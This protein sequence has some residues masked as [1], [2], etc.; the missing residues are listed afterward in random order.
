MEII[1][2]IFNSYT[3]QFG[4]AG[5]CCQVRTVALICE[6]RNRLIPSELQCLKTIIKQTAPSLRCL[7][8]ILI[9]L[10]NTRTDDQASIDSGTLIVTHQETWHN[11]IT[12]IKV[13]IRSWHSQAL[14][15]PTYAEPLTNL[16]ESGGP[17]ISICGDKM[18][19][20]KA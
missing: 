2:W 9:K 11:S 13:T 16:G 6:V 14:A 20:G 12:T 5:Q 17:D 15:F 3:I 1:L 4:V 19:S 7:R 8:Q 10:S 18:L